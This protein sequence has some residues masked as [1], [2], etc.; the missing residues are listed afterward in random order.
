MVWCGVVW[1]GVVWCGVVWCG[2]VWCG[3]VWC[4]VVLCGV[5]WCGVVWC[6]V[7]WCGVVWCGV[8]WCAEDTVMNRQWL[9][10]SCT[11]DNASPEGGVS[12]RMLP[13]V[14]C[15]PVAVGRSSLLRWAAAFQLD[16]ASECL[17]RP[18]PLCIPASLPWGSGQRITFSSPPH[19]PGAVG[20]GAPSVHSRTALGQGTADLLQFTASLLCALGNGSPCVHCLT[21]LGR[22]A[23][24]LFLVHYH[25]TRGQWPALLLL[26]SASLPWGSGQ[27]LTH[28]LGSVGSGTPSVRCLTALAVH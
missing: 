20:S 3:V 5:V 1:C 6:G 14:C 22:G 25:A 2:V 13:A 15:A 17:A 28:C 4:G 26:H 18:R 7:V 8:V 21:A 16:G 24:Q 9:G 11:R 19:C 27:S 10:W 23:V 12:K